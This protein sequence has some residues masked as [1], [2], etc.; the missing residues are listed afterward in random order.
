MS[1][2][3]FV[4]SFSLKPFVA[5]PFVAKPFDTQSTRSVAG[6]PSHIADC[7]GEKN[8]SEE[9]RTVDVSSDIR[10]WFCSKVF[11]R[12]TAHCLAKRLPPRELP[13]RGP[14]DPYL[15]FISK[16]IGTYNG[17]NGSQCWTECI[18]TKINSNGGAIK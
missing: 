17:W 9:R 4:G 18:G 14:E 2:L 7:N 16:S 15:P 8:A 13:F 12:N 6:R 11:Q 1:E 5:K 3:F 10:D